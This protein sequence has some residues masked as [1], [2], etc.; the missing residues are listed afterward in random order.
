MDSVQISVN[1]QD[2]WSELGVYCGSKQPPLLMSADNRMQVIFTSTSL[3]SNTSGFV[4]EFKFRTGKHYISFKVIIVFSAV[5]F[6]I[7]DSLNVAVISP[8]LPDFAIETGRQV[9][10]KDKS[11]YILYSLHSYFTDI[12][13]SALNVKVDG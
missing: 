9:S 11:E 2:K 6:G 10:S 3:K 1:N 5:Y 12:F 7:E 13:K 4:I 8:P